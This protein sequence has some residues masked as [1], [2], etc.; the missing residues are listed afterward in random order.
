MLAWA[1]RA[2]Y[3]VEDDTFFRKQVMLESAVACS[4]SCTKPEYSE[5]TLM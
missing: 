4:H 1:C 2:E 3:G 5:V